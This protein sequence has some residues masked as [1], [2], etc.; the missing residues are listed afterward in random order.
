MDF[1]AEFESSIKKYAVLEG[2]IF[3]DPDGESI[4]YEG[5]IADPF[6]IQ[7]AGAKMP[8]LME[9]HAGVLSPDPRCLEIQYNGYLVLCVALVENY[10]ITAI[11][12][13]SAYRECI[14]AH[15][16]ELA[17]KFNQEIV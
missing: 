6:H 8:I 9:Q 14:R 15:L 17:F 1:H 4:L 7:L 16:L 5:P 10:S 2:L 3:A 12:N 11:C 13:T